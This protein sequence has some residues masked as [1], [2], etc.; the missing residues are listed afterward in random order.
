MGTPSTPDH[1]LAYINLNKSVEGV[2]DL[3]SAAGESQL[4]SSKI[5][6]FTSDEIA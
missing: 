2:V 5:R 6:Y 1:L 3:E 4:I